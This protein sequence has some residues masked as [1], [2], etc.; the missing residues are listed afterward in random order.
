MK[1]S[2]KVVFALSLLISLIGLPIYSIN[3]L[4]SGEY[5]IAVLEALVLA[6]FAVGVYFD[7]GVQKML[8]AEYFNLVII[9][10]G[11]KAKYRARG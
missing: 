11:L 5:G 2:I 6:A 3:H 4:F 7:K 1:G 8:M 10:E 9:F